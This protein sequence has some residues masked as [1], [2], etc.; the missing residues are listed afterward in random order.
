MAD[1]AD[2]MD[3][4]PILV[5]FLI[6]YFARWES[7]SWTVRTLFVACALIGFAMHLR[8][9]WSTEVYEW[10]VS[11]AS[12]DVHPERNWDWKDPQFLRR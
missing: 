11:P 6:P 2:A 8:G 10:N 1:F 12:V 9:G 5:L 4:T 3:M 7:L